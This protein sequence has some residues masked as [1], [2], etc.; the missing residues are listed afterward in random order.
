ALCTAGIC[1][2]VVGLQYEILPAPEIAR[3]VKEF[4]RLEMKRRMT[5]CFCHIAEAR[6]ETTYDNFIR[7]FGERYVPGYR[8][9]SA[10]DLVVNAA[11]EESAAG[12]TFSSTSS[13][14]TRRRWSATNCFLAS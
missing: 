11:F 12:K 13:P 6:P 14:S 2:D 9:S 5:R 7:D 1:L 3:I 4:P 8:A 10:V